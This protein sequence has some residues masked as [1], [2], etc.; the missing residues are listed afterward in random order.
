MTVRQFSPVRPPRPVLSAA[1]QLKQQ[2]Q[3]EGQTCSPLPEL[4][5]AGD[6]G[7]Q[8]RRRSWWQQVEVQH[9]AIGLI[10]NHHAGNLRP[11]LVTHQAGGV[12]GQRRQVGAATGDEAADGTL[13]S[14]VWYGL[15]ETDGSTS[16]LQH[17]Q[18]RFD[19][20]V[21]H[22]VLHLVLTLIQVLVLE[23]PLILH[24]NMDVKFPTLSLSQLTHTQTHTHTRVLIP[25]S[26]VHTGNN[27]LMSLPVEC[28]S[29]TVSHQFFTLS[30]SQTFGDVQ[31][32][33]SSFVCCG[34]I[35]GQ[36]RDL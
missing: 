21:S 6:P 7:W 1:A 16:E 31:R 9:S 27:A 32:R 22:L 35:R 20:T 2:H 23:T 8:R 4:T 10:A 33:L 13:I 24:M 14:A 30:V 29:S 11:L 25:G 5:S 17:V 34:D 26:F 18:V 28:S 3:S 19:V 15:Q 36:N 12:P